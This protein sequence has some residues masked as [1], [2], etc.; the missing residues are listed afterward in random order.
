MSL[1][2]EN[3]EGTGEVYCD[4][5]WNEERGCYGVWRMCYRCCGS[6]KEPSWDV[7]DDTSWDDETEG[8]A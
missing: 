5:Q 4:Y 8:G 3:C 6:G 2:C 1:S 7:D